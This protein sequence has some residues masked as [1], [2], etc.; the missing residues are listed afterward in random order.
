MANTVIKL[1]KSSIP[2]EIPS[3]LEYGELAINYADGMLYYK[4]STGH[5]VGFSAAANVYSFATI[6]ANNSLITAI[7]NN[8][9][10]TINPGNNIEITGDII[11]DIVTIAANLK[12]AFDVANAAFVKANTSSANAFTTIAVPGQNNVVASV[13]DTLNFTTGSG[14]NISTNGVSKTLS[15]SIPPGTYS[16]DYGFIYE[17]VT[18]SNDYGSI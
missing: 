4:N 18:A 3:S 14:I 7:S 10:L 17:T 16:G 8:S 1:R 5:I 2:S 9:T 6:N 11:N 13:N 15:F 12:P